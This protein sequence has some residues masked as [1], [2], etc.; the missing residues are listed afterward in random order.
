MKKSLSVSTAHRVLL[1]DARFS[2]S[3]RQEHITQYVV[4]MAYLPSESKEISVKESN[5]R[6]PDLPRTAICM[7]FIVIKLKEGVI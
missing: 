4:C 5:I 7:E 6:I 2:L 3:E 1:G